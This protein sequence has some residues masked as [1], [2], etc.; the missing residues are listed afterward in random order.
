MEVYY[1][2]PVAEKEDAL[3]C[4][5]KLSVK[6]EKKV[7]INGYSTPCISA[8]LNPK[9]DMSRYNSD[10]FACLRIELKPEYCFIADKSLY[11]SEKTREL[12][13]RSIVSPMN[14]IFGTYRLPEC[15]VTCT[16]L[17]DSIS[18]MNRI[19]DSPVLYDSSEKLY[20]ANLVEKFNED[21]PDFCETALF[22]FLD[23][24]AGAGKLKK[25]ES[26][27]MAVFEGQDGKVYTLKKV[28]WDEIRQYQRI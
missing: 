2:I 12:Y 26:G 17:P 7:V 6:A 5:I 27:N 24:L 18:L 3:S 21:Y 14:Y 23:K 13:N 20:I 15:L 8:L 1:Y 19:I 22:I 10:R 16:I 25:I 11:G 28:G 4:G 9:D